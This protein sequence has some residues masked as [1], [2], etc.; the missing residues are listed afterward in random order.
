MCVCTIDVIHISCKACLCLN[1]LRK[2]FEVKWFIGARVLTFP[3]VVG[4][5]PSKI[6][7]THCVFTSLDGR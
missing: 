1:R 7:L 4:T 2:Q 5:F 6:N 3:V